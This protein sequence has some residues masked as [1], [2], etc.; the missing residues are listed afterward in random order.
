MERTPHTKTT[1]NP[2]TDGDS[3]TP[4]TEKGGGRGGEKIGPWGRVNQQKSRAR[5]GNQSNARS[6]KRLLAGKKELCVPRKK[7]EKG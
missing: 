4:A 5:R 7:G 2:Y 3:K 6:K 1:Q